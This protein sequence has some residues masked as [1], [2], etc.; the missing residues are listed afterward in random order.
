MWIERDGIKMWFE[1]TEEE[2]LVHPF[3]T[4]KRWVVS[5]PPEPPQPE[6]PYIPSTISMHQCRLY[7]YDMGTLAAVT[8]AVQQA[9]PKAQIE[10][11][12]SAE[13]WRSSPTVEQMRIM[14]GWTVEQMDQMFIDANEL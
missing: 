7:L 13:V 9:S 11:E 2:F 8:A 12:T 5:T 3:H 10:W 14:F 6:P 4:C 1:G